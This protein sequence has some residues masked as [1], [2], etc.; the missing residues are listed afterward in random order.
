MLLK[1]LQKEFTFDLQIKNYSKR[2]I[3]TYNWNLDQLTSYLLEQNDIS[4]VE[5]VSSLH[6]KKLIQYQIEM[7]NKSNY[8]NT[9]IK[10][11]R[12]F[13]S[14]LVSEEYVA[15]NIMS[16]I[17]LLKEDKVVIKTFTDK[18]VAR[19]IDANDFK[20]YLSARNKVIL[21]TFIDTGVRMSELIGIQSELVND[22]NIKVFGKGAKWRYV[23]VSLMLRKYM[24]RY[25]RIREV[26]FKDKRLEHGNYFLSRNGKP[27]TT[28]QIQNIV[29]EAGVKANVREDVRCSPH[30]LRHYSIQSNLRNGLDLYS[31]SKIAGHENILITKKYLLGI[32]A[33]NIL[34]IAKK[35]SPLMNL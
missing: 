9:I 8:I 24:I 3:E 22:T 30:T 26:Y 2:T 19:M 11:L 16:K 21:C 28:V 18:E 29:R 27:L 33:E 15:L 17:K 34:E 35:S 5:D 13:Y 10:S 4:E 23:P 1:D 6:I 14:Y 12:A 25:E 20:S 31:C 7:G 32:E